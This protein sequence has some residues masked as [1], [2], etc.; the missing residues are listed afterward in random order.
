MPRCAF[1]V[2]SIVVL[3][4]C[5]LGASSFFGTALAAEK[6]VIASGLESPESVAIGQGGRLFVTLIG[7]SNVNGDGAV[8]VIE[9][10]KPKTF[11]K[12]LDDPKG[13]AAHGDNL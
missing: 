12:G 2:E 9:G 7:K 3:S 1:R 8:A 13:L 5:L 10:G 4:T 6:Q 11:A